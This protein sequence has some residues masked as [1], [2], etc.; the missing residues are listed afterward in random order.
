M[1]LIVICTDTLRA[2]YL[3]CYGNDWMETPYLDRFAERSVLFENCYGESLPTV[4][5]RRIWFT[6]HSIMPFEKIK[7]PKGVYP[8]LPGWLPLRDQDESIAEILKDRGYYTGF[9]T[10][11]W[12]Y[13]KPNM[14]LHRGFCNW[15]FI[16]GQE[17][18]PHLTG[19]DYRFDPRK[20]ISENLWTKFY[21]E[22]VLQYLKN[23]QNFFSEEDYFCAQ[24]FRTAV[25]FLEDNVDRKPFFLWVDT[26]DPHEPF[27]CPREYALR[28]YDKYPCERYIFSYGAD[29]RKA[30]EEDVKCIR[31]VYCGLA[32]LVD[33]WAGHLLDAIER[34]GLF[35]DSVVVFTSDH[36]TEFMDHG[37]LQKHPQLLHH[38]VVRLPLI[39]HH[40]DPAFEGKRVSGLVSALD[41]MPTFLNFLG[42]EGAEKLEGED[43][44]P[45]ATG[46]KDAIHE[47]VI[48][49]YGGYGSIRTLDYNYIFPTEEREPVNENEIDEDTMPPDLITAL[50]E[51]LLPPRLYDLKADFDETKNV[52]DEHPD[53]AERHREWALEK[54]PNAPI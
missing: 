34:L 50:L 19:P 12:H 46:E 30:T 7:Q 17:Q 18:D 4:Q 21:H 36:G 52:I 54:W 31:G 33:R 23:T 26:F 11:L 20:H 9:I 47:Y 35:E 53:V 41:F 40:P 38:Q 1:N 42:E 10:D 5:A 44:W 22:R 24:T 45:L 25:R 27:D 16:R 6:G 37:H 29:H 13:F 8:D 2:D 14:N 43:F 32:S 51:P 28:Y 15:Q 49:G 39:I 48:S 3:G